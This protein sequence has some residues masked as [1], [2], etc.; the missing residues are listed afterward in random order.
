MRRIGID[1]GGTNTDAALVEG[2]AVLEAVK[3]PT[4]DDVLSGVVDALGAVSKVGADVAAVVIGTTHFTNAVVQRKGLNRVGFLRLALPTGRSLPPLV[5]WPADTVLDTLR[6][7]L[8]PEEATWIARVAEAKCAVASARDCGDALKRLGC[9][10]L[11][12][13]LQN[14]IDRCQ[15][16]A[17]PSALAEI[18]LLLQKKQA[19]LTKLESLRS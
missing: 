8:S 15:H 11:R 9:E 5:G 17:T 19:L 10:R 3:R 12:A 2:S 18:D 7:R 4:T 1:V 13:T 16:L 14:E 6:E